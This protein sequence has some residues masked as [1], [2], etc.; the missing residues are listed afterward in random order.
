MEDIKWDPKTQTFTESGFVHE[1]SWIGSTGSTHGT[2]VTST[3]IGYNYQ[4]PADAISGYPL[5]P[6][7]IQGIAPDATIIPVKVLADYHIGKSQT[8]E[9]NYP[10]QAFVMGTDRAVAAGI[11]YATNLK[12]AGYSPMVITM[13][14]GGPTPATVLENAINY[15]ISNDVKV[16]VAAGNE[17]DAG[18]SYPGAYSQVISVGS[19]GWKY[20]WFKPSFS[21][22]PTRYRLWWLQDTTYGFNDIPEPTPATQVYIS[23]FS[24][25]QKDGQEL[26]VVAPG[27]WVRGPYPGTPG[28]AHLPWWSN[29]ISAIIGRNPGHFYYL[30]GTSMATPHVASVIAQILEKNPALTQTQIETKL[31]ATALPIPPGSMSVYDIDPPEGFI[32]VTWGADATGA[33]LVQA[34]AAIAVA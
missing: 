13:S 9:I 28:Y 7:Y 25:R 22:P 11:V 12:I 30:G 24:S 20:E 33:G 2:H 15:A 21:P 32:T 8:D 29:G 18:M 26:D 17:G 27:S 5:P 16:V 4:A 6:L 31:K 14:L 19:C 1:T 3:I 23:D 34:K 10:D